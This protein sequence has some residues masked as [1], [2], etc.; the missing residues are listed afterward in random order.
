M[1]LFDI[2][3]ERETFDID[4]WVQSLNSNDFDEHLII[5]ARLGLCFNIRFR[6]I[7][8]YYFVTFITLG[9]FI[10]RITGYCLILV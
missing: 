6:I 4:H 3:L 8:I 10:Y 2:F 7:L 9:I 5:L 1:Y